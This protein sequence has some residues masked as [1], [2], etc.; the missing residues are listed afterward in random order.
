MK[1]KNDFRVDHLNDQGKAIAE[2]VLKVVRDRVGETASGGGCQAFYSPAEWAA[3]GE[4][5]GKL[6]ELII[7]HDG[8]DIAAFCNWG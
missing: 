1:T 3:R 5:Y 7:V 4:E 8:G 6:S 2:I